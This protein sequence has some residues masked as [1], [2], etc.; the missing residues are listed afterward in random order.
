MAVNDVFLFNN[1]IKA[2][3][4]IFGTGVNAKRAYFTLLNMG[5]EIQGFADRKMEL[6]GKKIFGKKIIYE[7][8]LKG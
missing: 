5:I 6:V 3:I 4:I 7:D 2:P 1:Q 8:N